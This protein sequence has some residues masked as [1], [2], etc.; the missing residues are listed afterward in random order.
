MPVEFEHAFP[1]AC[2]ADRRFAGTAQRRHGRPDRRVEG[3]GGRVARCLFRRLRQCL[4][5]F[6]SPGDRIAG[7]K[8]RGVEGA[9]WRQLRCRCC[10]RFILRFEEGVEPIDRR[11]ECGVEGRCRL[12]LSSVFARLG[13]AVARI[14]PLF[15]GS[16]DLGIER[17]QLGDQIVILADA[18]VALG[19]RCSVG[20]RSMP[21][22]S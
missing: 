18:T 7:G 13:Q 12:C 3:A 5:G 6:R 14:E 21:R 16:R 8:D 1:A 19:P 15:F 22:A 11:L 4:G 20:V 17:G 2:L 9:R 10:R